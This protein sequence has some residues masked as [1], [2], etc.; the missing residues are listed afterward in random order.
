VPVIVPT[1]ILTFSIGRAL[2][3]AC[4]RTVMNYSTYVKFQMQ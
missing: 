1:R 4:H 3:S 2:S